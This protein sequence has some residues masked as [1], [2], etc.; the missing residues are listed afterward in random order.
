MLTLYKWLIQLLSPFL[1]LYLYYRRAK[2]KEDSQRVQERFGLAT[3]PRPLGEIIHIHAASVGES[4]AV[5][6]LISAI[7]KDTPYKV[8]MTTGTITSAQLMAKQLPQGAIHQFIPLD[9]PQWVQRFLDHWQP[10]LTILV[11]SDLWPH[12]IQACHNRKIPLVLL[13]ARFSPQSR[14]RW[15]YFKGVAQTLFSCFDLILSQSP[16]VTRFFQSFGM[17]SIKTMGNIKFAASPLAYSSQDYKDLK[18][19]IGKRPIWLAASTHSG[20]EAVCLKTHLELRQ[21]FP[22]L[23]TIIVPRHPNR[24]E[25]IL[26]ELKGVNAILRTQERTIPKN[27][28]IYV[29]D[30]LGELGLFYALSPIAFVGGSFVP[31]GGHNPIEPALLDC[32]ILWGPQ[33]YNFVDV[34]HFLREAAWPLASEKE[35]TPVIKT[36]LK[37]PQIATLMGEH[38]K[39]LVESQQ[40]VL[41]QVMEWLAPYL[42]ISAHENTRLLA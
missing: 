11:E 33:T 7:V 6:P 26:S 34:S 19:A 23:L 38:A 3:Q 8:L 22:N 36:L 29:A 20:E 39:L 12:L 28:E 35:L 31:V 30:T 2:G 42:K 41:K 32:A 14:R 37:E 21:I 10:A 40:Q 16:E 1:R 25:T 15:G 27:C 4:L 9:H 18:T 24:G 17:T 13:N 5:L